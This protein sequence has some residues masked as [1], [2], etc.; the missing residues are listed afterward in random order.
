MSYQVP[1]ILH[2]HR[3]HTNLVDK[4]LYL[5]V[6]RGLLFALVQVA[7]MIGYLSSPGQFYWYASKLYFP[8]ALP[9]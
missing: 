8:V 3:K 5:T 6:N 4:L 2:L 7:R 1:L 9:K